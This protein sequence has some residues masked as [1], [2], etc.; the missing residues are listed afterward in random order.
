MLF[1]FL[2]RRVQS[3]E[4]GEEDNKTPYHTS[5]MLGTMPIPII[6]EV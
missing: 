1:R 5:M 6:Y 2:V 3:E 4:K